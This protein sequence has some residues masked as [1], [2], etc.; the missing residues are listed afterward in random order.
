MPDKIR[1]RQN[2][3]IK[4]KKNTMIENIHRLEKFPGIDVA[5]TICQNGHYTTYQS[6]E[7]ADF[8]PSKEK[9]VSRLLDWM[10]EPS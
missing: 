10:D 1:K 6:P 2:E 4:R 9:I 5:F 3:A 8:P 7:G